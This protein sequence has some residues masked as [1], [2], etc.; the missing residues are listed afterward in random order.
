M[1]MAVNEVK[2]AISSRCLWYGSHAT[3]GGGL[4]QF[5]GGDLYGP[6]YGAPSPDGR[7]RGGRGSKREGDTESGWGNWEKQSET[8]RRGARKNAPRRLSFWRTH[9]SK[10]CT[11]TRGSSKPTAFTVSLLAKEITS[12]ALNQI[13]KVRGV[14]ELSL[15]HL[16][17]LSALQWWAE[18]KH[19]LNQRDIERAGHSRDYTF[20]PTVDSSRFIKNRF[21]GRFAVLL[22]NIFVCLLLSL[23]FPVQQGFFSGLYVGEQEEVKQFPTEVF[24]VMDVDTFLLDTR[25]TGSSLSSTSRRNRH[26]RFTGL[27]LLVSPFLPSSSSACTFLWGSSQ[28]SELQDNVQME[29]D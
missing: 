18:R 25:G 16:R 20:F 7:E 29:S 22:Q 12:G 3:G 2:A 4:Q 24:W 1:R 26:G 27:H 15:L 21:E 19:T 11:R 14:S 28:S 13:N 8:D 6:M 23:F 5:A 17:I 9:A 10:T